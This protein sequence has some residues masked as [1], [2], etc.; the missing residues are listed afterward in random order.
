MKSKIDK[1]AVD[2]RQ[3]KIPSLDDL[4][5]EIQD[6][7]TNNVELE[8]LYKRALADYQNL[9]KRQAEEREKIAKYSAE[10]IISRFL[11][12]LEAL[13]NS[14]NHLKDEG[15]SKIIDMMKT[16]FDNE[17][18]SEINPV[19]ASFDPASHEAIGESEGKAN[20][21]V[22]VHRKGYKLNGK[23]IR[24]AVVT[25]GNGSGEVQENV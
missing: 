14:Q 15:I 10:R 9:N 18:L 25:V 12:V 3:E 1:K 13:E 24:P 6:C 8:Q 21:V 20:I 11:D 16:V 19:G 22:S 7:L 2:K 17:G 5:K 23:V 4:N